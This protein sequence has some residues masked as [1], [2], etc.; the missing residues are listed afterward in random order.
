MHH[1]VPL[2]EEE[3]EDGSGDEE[4]PGES[5]MDGDSPAGTPQPQPQQQPGGGGSG[6]KTASTPTKVKLKG[7]SKGGAVLGDVHIDEVW[8]SDHKFGCSSQVPHVTLSIASRSWLVKA[9]LC[10]ETRSAQ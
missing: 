6:G 2:Q 9:S 4:P 3:D 10:V 1:V 5:T 8:K 7:K